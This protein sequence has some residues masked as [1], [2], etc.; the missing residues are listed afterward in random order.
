MAVE[1]ITQEGEFGKGFKEAIASADN[2]PDAPPPVSE[3]TPPTATE[4]KTEEATDDKDA[5]GNNDAAKEDD[6]A[7]TNTPADSSEVKAPPP[8]EEDENS[9][10]YK[11]RWRSLE[12]M[13]PAER[14]KA[15]AATQRAL[16]AEQ[17]LESLRKEKEAAQAASK[18]VTDIA[19]IEATRDELRSQYEDALLAGDKEA[20]G[21]SWR[22][23]TA[24]ERELTARDIYAKMPEVA[25]LPQVIDQRIAGK[26]LDTLFAKTVDESIKKYPFLDHRNPENLAN[27]KEVV[28]KRDFY[29][30]MRGMNPVEALS[31]AVEEVAAIVQS[32]MPPKTSQQ[33]K[34]PVVK[35]ESDIK[36]TVAVSG[37]KAPVGITRPVIDNNDFKSSFAAAI[38]GV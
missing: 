1:E 13:L 21:K 34:P 9:K 16:K 33:A 14:K 11:Q 32:K 24:I 8:S 27:V 6:K 28:D 4:P 36:S 20:A 5:D 25:N 31:T 3:Q 2:A 23:L 29:T 38:R 12:G 10:S 18:K 7:E 26:E 17:E 15:E 35:P 37:K 30:H 19:E 22:N